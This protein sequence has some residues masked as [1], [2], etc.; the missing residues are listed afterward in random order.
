MESI[1]PIH[2]TPQQAKARYAH[3]LLILVFIHL[4][5]T[6]VHAQ[7]TPLTTLQT[8]NISIDDTVLQPSVKR[9]GMNLGTMTNYDS[10]QITQNLLMQNPGFEGQIWNSTIRCI[11]GTATSCTDENQYSGWPAHFWDGATFE[12]FY[13]TA[14]GRTGTITSSTA[15][16]N[17]QG[18]TLNFSSAGTAPALGD[19]LIVRK[20]VPGGASGG[21]FPSTSGA[22]QIT[23]NLTD[24][25]PGTLGKQ[26]VALNA[27]TASDRAAIAGYFD[28]LANKTFVQLNG[29]YQLQ[30]KAKGTGGSSQIS[31]RLARSNGATYLNQPLTL[32]SSW[33][34]YTANFTASENGS[35]IGTV[36]VSFSTVGADA[37]EL[38][39]VSLTKT[40]GDSSNRTAFRDPVVNALRTLQPGVLRFWGGQLGETLDNL[41]TPDFG[42]QRAGYLT[43]YTSAD[44]IDFG[45]HDFLVLCQTVGA[46]PWF[47]VPSTFSTA[48]AAHLIDYL[49]GDQSSAYGAKRA[50]LGQ[51]TP[52]T[53]IFSKIHLEFG[54]EA[55]NSTFEGGSILYPAAYA[56]RA[57]TMFGV[58]R[59]NSFYQAVN[60]DLVLGGQA[61]NPWLNAAIQ[62]GCNNNDSFDIAPYTMSKVD[63]Y[64][65]TE[66]LYGSTFAE[67]EAFMASSGGTAEGLSPGMVY[68]DYQAIQNS[69]HPVPLSF[70][71]IN[72]STI[73]GAISQAALDSYTPSL[74][75]GLMVADTMLLGLRQFGVVNQ[76]LFAL[77]QYDFY[78][79]DGKTVLLWG[80][81]V[82]MGVTDR[83]RPQ[84][85]AEQLANQALNNGAAML[86]TTHTGADPT[87][88][89]PL[90]NTVQFNNA[91]DL[92]SFAFSSGGNRSAVIMNL[93]RTTALPVTFSGPNAPSGTVQMQQL[94]ATNLSDT[95][96]A[97]NLVTITPTTLNRFSA[98][99]GLT[100]PAHSMTVLTW[101]ANASGA[102][103]ITAVAAVSLTGTSA[104]ITWTTDQPASSQVQYGTGNVYGA[105]SALSYTLVNLHSVT[106]TGLTPGTTYNYDVVSTNAAGTSATSS[107]LTFSTVAA[108]TVP[109]VTNTA[110]AATTVATPASVTSLPATS[111]S[112]AL[113]TAA[114]P[115]T[116]TA[117]TAGST[118]VNSSVITWT[119]DQASTSQVAYG[120]STAYGSSTP[121]DNSLVTSH[122]VTLTGL[123]PATTYDYQAVSANSSGTQVSSANFTVST[124]SPSGPA[125]NVSYVAFWGITGSSIIISW[126]TDIP[127]TTT[128]QY[129][130]SAALGQTAI[131][132][133]A[134]TNNHGI[135]LTGLNPATTYYFVAQSTSASA[136]VGNSITYSFTTSNTAPP[137]VAGIVVV[138]GNN[139]T[140]Q[141]SWTTSAPGFSYLQYGTTTDYGWWTSQTSL[142][143]TPSVSL[144]WVPTGVIHYHLVSMDVLGNQTVSPDYT[145]TEP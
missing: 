12:I 119:T 133:T 126:S 102:P 130:T 30:F 3:C 61:A 13:G 125:P 81:V 104:T 111:T 68:Q 8:T 110:S 58:M 144:G 90:V 127:S 46:E 132:S 78:R 128:V 37:F 143:T 109:V 62:N 2:F 31:L 106:L 36:G 63:S 59:A 39:D 74:G 95:N 136:A 66:S 79:P 14:A 25:P 134:L 93:S 65:D 114:L 120:T 124:P 47:V 82:D 101:L 38:D 115:P 99:A 91:H 116:I 4:F 84:F 100:L 107:A 34:T 19:Y 121:T 86:Q 18:L 88:N 6:S 87:W 43:W 45:L 118:T 55:W 51:T 137:A 96:E 53:Q 92:H 123:S 44:V 73:D 76:E 40:G 85:L 48:D 70:Y 56:S 83:R 139:H 24:L 60:F 103:S 29:T 23:D 50:A 89:Q 105:S 141:V 28:S 57:Q 9:F 122:T 131:G 16:A 67:P 140:A 69:S 112:S 72:L 117:V 26:T 71:E 5:N 11:A 97:S 94:T 108:V 32:T 33:N 52:W 54:N 22:G 145:F 15:P 21:W 64:A 135:T 142:T 35:A 41:I 17:G 77:P 129:G 10:G 1:K 113:T 49:A 138:P 98:A 20:T 42:R 7:T 80:S 27:P 75:A